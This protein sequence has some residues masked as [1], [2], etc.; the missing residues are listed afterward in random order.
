MT[1]HKRGEAEARQFSEAIIQT[2]SNEQNKDKG[3]WQH[4]DY[5]TLRRGLVEEAQEAWEEAKLLEH[6]PDQRREVLA[7]LMSECQDTAAYALMLWDK[8]R[9]E[10]EDSEP[11]NKLDGLSFFHVNGVCYEV[12][13]YESDNGY[14]AF[15]PQMRGVEG[16]DLR[17]LDAFYDLKG[18]VIAE[19]ESG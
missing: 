11:T 10:L 13:M 7:D 6:E 8:A 5:L 19:V 9:K 2:L 1:D 3:D 12:E 4:H 16:R 18:K 14:S 15:T 17:Q